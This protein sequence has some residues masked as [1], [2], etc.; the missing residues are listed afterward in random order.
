MPV[1]GHQIDGL[2][3]LGHDNRC[4]LIAHLATTRMA[5]CQMGVGMAVLRQPF[6]LVG[7]VNV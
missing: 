1:T 6:T 7:V 3:V 5:Y 2:G 4:A